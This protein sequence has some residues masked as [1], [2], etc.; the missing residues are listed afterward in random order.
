MLDYHP[1][2]V[3]RVVKETSKTVV[4]LIFLSFIVILA[5]KDFVPVSYIYIW[6][7]A[8][9]VFV[10][11][12]Y[13]NAQMLKK[14]I[15]EDNHEGIRYHMII[16][17]VIISISALLWNAAVIVGS[18]YAPEDYEF[19]SFIL[20]IGVISGGS[21]SLAPVVNAY[22][23][24]LFFM[25]FPQFIYVS[26]MEGDVYLMIA[27]LCLLYVPFMYLLSKS[28]YLNLVATIQDNEKLKENKL[29][30][31]L[32]KQKAEESTKAKSDFL[33]NMSHEI[34]TPMNGIIGM[35]RMALNSDLNTKQ[36]HYIDTINNSA[37]SLLHII[38]DILDFSK[39]EAGKLEIDTTDFNLYHLV[40]TIENTLRFKAKEKGL[41]FEV[42]FA[43][44]ISYELHGDS[45][46]IS[47][48]LINLLNNA[49]KFTQKGFVKLYI[50]SIEDKF[51][52]EI[53]D[54]GIG[55][56]KEQ[57]SKLFQSFSQADSSTTRRYGGTG[58]GLSIS[59]QL[60]ELMGGKIWVESELGKGSKFCFELNLEKAKAIDSI[61]KVKQYTLDD[62][63]VLKGSKI[64]LT[65][66]NSINQEIIIGL[67]ENSGIDIDIASNG[68][69]AIEL[70]TLNKNKYELI[71]M[72]LQMPIMDGF[73]ATKN[74]RVKDKDIPII[75]LTA[76]AMKEDIQNTQD[77]GMNEHLNKPIEVEIL[78]ETLLKYISTKVNSEE[79]IVK[80]EKLQIPKFNTIDTKAGLLHMGNSEKLYL[81]ILA[82]FITSYE[83]I[84]FENFDDEEFKRAIHTLKGLSA[85]IGAI[86]INQIALE[87]ENTK[88]KNSLS[89]LLSILYE[90]LTK[91]IDE[92]KEKL[93]ITN[94]TIGTK[95]LLDSEKRDQLIEELKIAVLS[96]RIKK[97]KPIIEEIE[98]YKL[99]IEDKELFDT[100]INYIKKYD[101]KEAIKAIATK[102]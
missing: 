29:F 92:L 19:F 1:K 71:L 31:E 6:V 33:A 89:S 14:N 30:L 83:D 2:L 45:L 55:M 101:F 80:S 67:L 77:A 21:V 81:K 20:I 10:I 56:T 63:K 40:D 99:N 54:T 82:E 102:L 39:I 70:F 37:S 7:L 22:L 93:N 36:K 15:D 32:A 27:L 4:V 69:E 13:K 52:F 60:V 16:F 58:L 43:N 61:N 90:E 91:T 79:L 100:V 34:R 86:K 23:F 57:Q 96:K 88:D 9:V 18:I 68:S 98:Q 28:V 12:R 74:I 35:T 59:K 51:V 97:C 47:Q 49:L 3:E 75:A 42:E 46:R 11:S 85:N 53:I 72:D 87:I 66:D 94:L 50:F 62:I 65:E 26:S 24:Y 48:I 78:Y 8:Q 64:L 41:I 25:I 84:V 17:V 95:K 38:N 73:E 5:F 44:K 76:N